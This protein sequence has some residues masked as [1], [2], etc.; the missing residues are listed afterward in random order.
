[1]G[2]Q[3]IFEASS[4][5]RALGTTFWRAESLEGV[6]AQGGW[7]LNVGSEGPC[8]RPQEGV[9]TTRMPPHS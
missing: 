1:M 8:G 5:G 4:F 7:E 2:A 6:S 3:Y 9:A